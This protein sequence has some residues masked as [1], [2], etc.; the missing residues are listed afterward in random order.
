[1]GYMYDCGEG[2]EYLDYCV[3]QSFVERGRIPQSLEPGTMAQK[4]RSLIPHPCM[5]NQALF[6]MH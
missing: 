6:P 5:T 1:M 3:T 4:V 2:M